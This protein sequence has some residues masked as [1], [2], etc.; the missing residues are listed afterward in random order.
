MAAETFQYSYF[1]VAP[2]ARIY[3]HLSEPSN[4]TG[5]SPLIVQV[6]NIVTRTD[7]DGRGVF[8]YESV[9]MFR[10]F[11]F[12]PYANRLKVAT[13]LTQPDRQIVSQVDSPFS[14]HVQFIFDLQPQD[15]GTL[16]TETITAHM[17][18]IVRGFVVRQAK[19]V[20]RARAEILRSRMEKNG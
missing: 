5:L 20:Q 18:W 10:F 12:I 9:E 4:Y 14:V 13:T 1:I 6:D 8:T 3:A 15:N 7:P 2:P 17:P 11:G 16:L 19:A